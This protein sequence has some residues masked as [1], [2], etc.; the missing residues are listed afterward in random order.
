MLYIS[1][2]SWSPDGIDALAEHIESINASN[3][4]FEVVDPIEAVILLPHSSDGETAHDRKDLLKSLSD[5]AAEK[6]VFLA[7][8][9][10]VKSK[11]ADVP[12]TLGFLISSVGKVLIEAEKISPELISGIASEQSSALGQAMDFK[13]ANT[14][15]GQVGRHSLPALC[16]QLGVERRGSDSQ[17]I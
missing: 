9:V 14:P 15:I 3:G 17:S 8:S 2:K 6:N 12:C 5:L 1:Q 13:V 4:R 16:A 11:K 10:L 7:G